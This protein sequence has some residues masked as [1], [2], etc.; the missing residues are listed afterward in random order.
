[1]G[2]I[3][4]AEPFKDL[5]AYR[6]GGGGRAFAAAVA[7]GQDGVIAEVRAAGLRGRGG[8]GFPTAIKWAGVAESDADERW[9]VCNAAEGE[10][11]TFKDR[12]IIRANPYAVLEGVAVAAFAVGAARAYVGIKEKFTRELARLVD[13][14]DELA[15]AGLLGDVE[16]VVVPGPDDY[17]FGEEKGLLEVIEGR[18]PLPRLY[19]P[20]VRG[21]FEE[22]GGPAKPAVVNNVETLANV[23]W[24]VT[25]GA[26]AHRV[27][28]TDDSPGTIVCTVGGDVVSETVSELA[29]GTPLRHL[30]E[31][32][33]GGTTGPVKL[34]LNGASNAPLTGADLDTPISWEGMA[35]AGSGL[36]SAGFTVFDESVC[37]VRVAA[38]VSSFLYRGSCGQ[39]PPCKLGTAA[40]TEGF[41][42]LELGGDPDDVDDVA[43]WAQRVTDANR[44]GLGAGARAFT[45]G[46]LRHFPEDVAHHLDGRGCPSDRTV[47]VTTIL[48][49]DP[50]THRF[51]Y[52]DPVRTDRPGG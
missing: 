22:P 38:A 16:V 13:A 23:P 50:T 49:H 29:L 8:A 27:L 45:V 5:D 9:V 28:G 26:D 40:I 37:A 14:H 3:L 15:S 46:V 21:L 6:A 44:C 11:G 41:V 7:R 48:D 47:S 1:M 30:V 12:S 19:P 20:Y 33:A 32:V 10:P 4:P 42:A 35:E 2:R 24:I 18:D 36:G 52:A 39:C 25:D 51:T 34:V 17:L 31:D 43:A